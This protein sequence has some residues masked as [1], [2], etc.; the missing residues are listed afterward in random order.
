MEYDEE[1][2]KRRYSRANDKR[3]DFSR[4]VPGDIALRPMCCGN[5]VSVSPKTLSFVVPICVS[6]FGRGWSGVPLEEIAASRFLSHRLATIPYLQ[7]IPLVPVG[8]GHSTTKVHTFIFISNTLRTV[9][10]TGRYRPLY[11]IDSILSS[12]SSLTRKHGSRLLSFVIF[13]S[14]IWHSIDR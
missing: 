13:I 10:T 1:Q 6:L 3:S 4:A 8:T 7:Y 14:N 12:S 5:A 11:Y 2:W 9:H